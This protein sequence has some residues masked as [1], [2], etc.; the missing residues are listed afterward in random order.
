MT[1]GPSTSERADEL[2]H[3]QM[4]ELGERI[5]GKSPALQP[6]RRR[7]GPSASAP[8]AGRMLMGEDPRL[9]PLP[10]KPTLLDFFR[11]R[12]AIA[13]QAH[14]LQSANLA[15][16]NDLSDKMV[17]GL[18][19][20]RHRGG[21]FHPH[22]PRLLGRPARRALR[23]RG[24]ELGRS[25]P[26]RPCASFPTNRSGTTTRRTTACSSATTTSRSPTWWPRT[27]RARSHKWY[28]SARVICVN[29]LYSF[30]PDVHVDLEQFEDVVGPRVPAAARGARQRQHAPRPTCGGRCAGPATRSSPE[31]SP[32]FCCGR[33]SMRCD[34][35]YSL[36]PPRRSVGY[37]FGVFRSVRPLTAP[38][39]RP[40]DETW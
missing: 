38:S 12:F 31:I 21:G 3:R 11:C 4:R 14:L 5:V 39:R 27:R 18:P 16:K 19:A 29:D 8:S 34:W 32:T 36:K 33:R 10:E 35:P 24:G 26:T 30:D 6:R 13:P 17:L 28:M 1:N 37:A 9:P 40:R 2:E 23:G 22:R 20:A 15:Q 25:A 7:A